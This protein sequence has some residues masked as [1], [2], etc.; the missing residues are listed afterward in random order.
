[1]S[2]KC[3]P[4]VLHFLTSDDICETFLG[5]VSSLFLERLSRSVGVISSAF[6][7][8]LPETLAIF[9]NGGKDCTVVLYLLMAVSQ[10]WARVHL[11]GPPLENPRIFFLEA[12]S[13]YPEVDA[14]IASVQKQSLFFL[15]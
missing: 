2:A 14:F 5:S 11:T 10:W 12:D 8:F 6:E 9:F 1:M 4:E 13:P 15:F 3:L 7:R